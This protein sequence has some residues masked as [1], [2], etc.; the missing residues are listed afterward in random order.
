MNNYQGLKVI[1]K[2]KMKV[3][4][5]MLRM[6]AGKNHA[7][8]V[9][10]KNMRSTEKFIKILLGLNIISVFDFVDGKIGAHDVPLCNHSGL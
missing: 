3:V 2:N 7:Y 10:D 9:A 5:H 8:A 4:L 1:P 6:R